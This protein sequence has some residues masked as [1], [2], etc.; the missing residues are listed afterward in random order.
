MNVKFISEA[1]EID[2]SENKLVL[3][4]INEL[5]K[6]SFF[7]PAYQRGYRWTDV[8][9]E[10]LLNDIWKF[11]KKEKN[12]EDFY[13]LQPVVVKSREEKNY[14]VIDGQQRLTTIYIILNYFNK[15]LTEEYK[16]RLYAI[17]YETRPDSFKFLQNIDFERHEENIDYFH[18]Y[19]AYETIKNWFE[20]KQ[21]II[22]DFESTVINKTK[23]IW[24][25]TESNINSIDIFTR[26]NIGKIPL[27][28]A[29]LVK[30][31]LLQNG[32]FQE[33]KVCLKQ[34]Q[35]ASE[36]DSIE[37]TLQDNAF[38]YF[39]YNP[40]NS[41]KYDN[42]IEY[43]FDLMKNKK[44][45][46]ETDF[47]FNEFYK[48]FDESKQGKGSPDIDAIWLRIKNYF[49]SFEEWYKNKELYHLIGFLVDCGYDINTLKEKTRK[50]TKTAFKKYLK[51]EIKKGIECQIDELNYGDKHIKKI[52]LLFNIQTILATENTDMRF[53]FYRYKDEQW[54]I[55][56]VR[57]QTEKQITGNT[58]KEW[59]IDVLEYFTGQKGYSDQTEKEVHKAAIET[60]QAKE[61]EYSNRLI[62]MLDAEKI[63]DQTF[64]QLYK[65]L[66]SLFQESEEP[67][68]IDSISNLALLDAATNRSYKN[69][70]F[71]IKRK[72]IIE[73]DMSGV[74]IPICTKNVFLKSYSK[75]LGEVMYWKNSD[76]NDY[77]TEI[78]KTL[79]EY[80][81][82][83]DENNE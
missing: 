14:E 56:H 16:K 39:I 64:N 17:G 83:R 36:W 58:R 29:E 79:K 43:I 40:D 9:V 27:T 33:G 80:L 62:K 54:D 42:R 24:Y 82:T 51:D 6:N 23:V 49:L 77:L 59:T 69:A 73:N 1:K 41:L 15:R 65:D 75:R 7:I 13:C 44:K 28:N 19:K 78:K 52:L 57:S 3:K 10:Q 61:Q 60:L 32:N 76:A 67:E 30:A 31:L 25:E 55:E 2:M 47:T 11:A 68:N 71:P 18:I 38:W 48:E 22:N 72:T 74:F 50:R 46:D 26:I 4:S 35:I 45:D 12:N 8:Q 5:L 37:K 53:P 20:D 21:N 70:M 66:E 81:P 34:L 63:D